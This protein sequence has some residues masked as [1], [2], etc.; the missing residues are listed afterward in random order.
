M[1]SKLSHSKAL[2]ICIWADYETGQEN[3]YRVGRIESFLTQFFWKEVLE[4]LDFKLLSNLRNALPHQ[5]ALEDCCYR[6]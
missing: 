2:K 4:R 1:N 3:N 5:T 6:G